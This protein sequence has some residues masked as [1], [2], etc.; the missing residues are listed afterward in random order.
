[1]PRRKN[2]ENCAIPA[3]ASGRLDCRE[4]RFVQIGNTLFFDQT[5]QLLSA[6]AKHLYFCMFAECGGRRTF[7]FP[8][9]AA[10]KYGIPPRSFDRYSAELVEAG[11][12]SKTSGKNTRTA[13]TFCFEFGWKKR[14]IEPP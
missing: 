5:F 7:D 11:F 12:L 8:H 13:N 1:M 9:G 3:W 6:G 4:K 14:A 10:K 2:A